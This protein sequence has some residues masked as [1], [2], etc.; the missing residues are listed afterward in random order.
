MTHEKAKKATMQ[1]TRAS[2]VAENEKITKMEVCKSSPR[3]AM[4]IN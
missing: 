4:K 1:R 2:I 3:E